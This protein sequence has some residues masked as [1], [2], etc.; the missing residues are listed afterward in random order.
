VSADRPSTF[1]VLYVEDAAHQASLVEAFFDAMPGYTVVHTHRGDH[2]IELIRSEGWDL[3]VTDLNLPGSDGFAVIRAMRAASTT[4]PV[5]VTTGYAQ[6][7]YEEQALRAGADQV[8]IKPLTQSDFVRR[9]HAMIERSAPT[10]EPRD[11]AVVAVEG[12]LG[13]A[14]M[15]CGG[16]LMKAA[17]SG[18][19]VVIVPILGPEGDDA[20]AVLNAASTSAG[21]L[22][23]ELRA[24]RTLFGRLDAQA[25]FLERLLLELEPTTVYLPAPGDREENRRRAS[26]LGQAATSGVRQ[27][28]GYETATTGPDFV[29]THFVDVHSQM[30]TKLEAL[31]AYQAT[32]APRVDL[33]PG[34]AQ[35]YARYWGRFR[36][37]AEV[38]AFQEMGTRAW[39]TAVRT[40]IAIVLAATALAHPVAAQEPAP[41]PAGVAPP[42]GPY[43]PGVDVVHYEVEVG[44]GFGVLWFEGRTDVRVAVQEDEAVLPLDFSGLAVAEVLLD[45]RQ[46]AY[47]HA[48]G[49]LRVPLTGHESGDTATVTVR[50][51]GVPDDGLII[52]ENVHGEP[53][54]FVDN[55]PNRTRFWL[56]SV[57]HP[58]DKATVRYTVHAPAAWKVIANGHLAAGP[59]PT[60]ADAIGPKEDRRSWTWEVGVPI[61]PYNMVIG[62]ADLEVRTVGLAACGRAPA[63][64]R[65]DGCVEVTYWVYPQDVER[66][67]PSFRRA[68]EMVDHFTEVVGPFPFE[69]LANVQSATRFGGMENASAIFYSERGIAEG[70]N[71]EGTV[72]HEIAHQWFGDAVTEASWHHLWL[73]EGFATYFGAQFFEAADGVE[74]FRARMEQSRQ[75]VLGSENA[76]R[77]V[78][79]PEERNLFA[80]LNDNNYPKGGWVLHMLR[81]IVGDDAFFDGIRAYYARHVHTAVLTEDFQKAME[82][83]AGQDLSWFFQQWIYQPGYPTFETEWTWTAGDG[84]DGFVDLTV[85]QVQR[86]DWPT[87]RVPVEVELTAGGRTV[88][89]RIEVRE[90]ETTVRLGWTG[91]RPD[92]VVLDPDRW[93]LTGGN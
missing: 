8:M 59:T 58:A 69:K 17:A 3:L 50:Y 86:A 45:G 90:R 52:R 10:E 38:E 14:D 76:N 85:R 79:D 35:A 13:D 55:W 23:V 28:L 51:E 2:A 66:A 6:A 34:M 78:Y 7:G 19:H 62:A 54:A 49:I 5:L 60:P 74:A 72:S 32:V 22:G 57:D 27:V 1:R 12:M 84:P 37:F 24:D 91:P 18:A 89:E 9:V 65:A 64:R 82:G 53:A 44:L 77:P 88:R 36:D 71:I 92:Q 80:L 41:I 43:A 30:L 20:E 61:S 68:A 31:C 47:D 15:G 39:R 33:R 16:S 21:I 87:F 4:V 70:R 11:D 25:H 73:S 81:G 46:A 56:P 83:V 40:G 48:E 93:V 26:I 63:V 75:R 29:P 42:P 67:E